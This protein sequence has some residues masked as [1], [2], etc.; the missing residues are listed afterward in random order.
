VDHVGVDERP[1][2]REIL[3]GTSTTCPN[4]GG[5]PMVIARS[6]HVRRLRDRL[7]PRFDPEVVHREICTACDARFPAGGERLRQLLAEAA[8]PPDEPGLEVAPADDAPRKDSAPRVD[9]DTVRLPAPSPVEQ[10]PAPVGGRCIPSPAVA[11]AGATRTPT[12]QRT[13]VGSGR[14]SGP[15]RRAD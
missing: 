1:R 4:C 14:R 5:G 11:R 12:T 10:P 9:A 6:Q 15:T 7:N 2:H 13:R 8:A 3:G